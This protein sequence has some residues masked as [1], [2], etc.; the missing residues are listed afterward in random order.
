MT[1]DRSGPGAND[2]DRDPRLARFL[3]R[4]YAVNELELN[5]VTQAINSVVR[6]RSNDAPPWWVVIATW[7]RAVVPIGLAVAATAS[8]MLLRTSSAS[9][10]ARASVQANQ[11]GR[12]VSA[13]EIVA[14]RTT[15][16]DV[17]AALLPPTADDLLQAAVRR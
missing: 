4:E 15:S 11:S 1:I 14:T 8:F 10:M 3:Q 6:R 5:R 2:P 9:S 17:V 13:V 12:G 7:S 16:D